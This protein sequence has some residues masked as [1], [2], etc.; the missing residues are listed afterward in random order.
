MQN[1]KVKFSYFL[2]W[3][4]AWQKHEI[5]AKHIFN[6]HNHIGKL[7]IESRRTFFV[8]FFD[9]RNLERKS[10]NNLTFHNSNKKLT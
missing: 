1:K 8:F 5:N 6:V 4:R 10:I 2:D 7:F 3:T 9:I